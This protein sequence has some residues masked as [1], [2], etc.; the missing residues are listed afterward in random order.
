MD[1]EDADRLGADLRLLRSVTA[2]GAREG[3][4]K[5]EPGR[6]HPRM[7]TPTLVRLRAPIAVAAAVLTAACSES[8]KGPPRDPA[9]G[10]PGS[11]ILAC[12][13]TTGE[14][15]GVAVSDYIRRAQPTAQ[16]YLASVGAG[17]TPMPEPGMR[18]LKDKGPTYLYPA[19]AAEQ[20]KVKA[21]LAEVGPYTSLL[22]TFEGLTYPGP[23]RATVRLG[24]RYVGGDHDGTVAPLRTMQLRCEGS[25]WVVTGAGEERST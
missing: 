12:D 18:A 2:V 11:T 8:G 6:L 14:A 4:D 23:D 13:T 3:L 16:R 17:A 15:V 21:R 19:D 1:A 9:A 7:P 20:E 22:V 24:G 10:T 5:S 25:K